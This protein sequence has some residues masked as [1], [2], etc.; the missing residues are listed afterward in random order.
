[1][2][3][4]PPG[5]LGGLYLTVEDEPCIGG[6]QAADL[7]PQA[8]L[9]ILGIA[10]LQFLDRAH[11]LRAIDILRKAVEVRIGKGRRREQEAENSPDQRKGAKHVS[12]S[13][14]VP[15]SGGSLHGLPFP[16]GGSATS[17]DAAVQER[18]A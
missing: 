7:V 2:L 12:L 10:V 5:S 8:E 1:D 11:A 14:A 18:I 4:G 15:A 17:R 6:E 13:W 9:R 3:G 16:A